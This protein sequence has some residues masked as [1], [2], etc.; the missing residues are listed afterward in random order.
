MKLHIVAHHGSPLGVTEKSIYGDGVQLGVGGSELYLLTM[1]RAWKEAGHDVTLYNNPRERGAS[2]FE[3]KNLTEFDPEEWRDVLIIFRAENPRTVAAKCGRKIFWSC[4]QFTVGNFY[5]LA[6]RVDK[7]VTI[8]PFH[9][10]YFRTRYNIENSVV[11]DIPVREWDY[12]G[13]SVEKDPMQVL[14]CSVPDRGINEL[15]R[16]WGPVTEEVPEAK[17]HI[18]SDYRLWDAGLS[19]NISLKHKIKFTSFPNVT[20]HALVPRPKLIELQIQ[21]AIQLYPCTYEELF[22]I[23]TAE[24]CYAGAYPIT[25]TCGALATTN[26]GTKIG[27]PI[28]D[29]EIR[30]FVDKTIHCLKNQETCLG[31]GSAVQEQA[32]ERF[33]IRKAI[34]KW[35]EVIHE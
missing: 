27:F 30:E 26:L 3:Q 29:K 7:V 28:G 14:F 16:I 9:Q 5:E 1:C 4:D 2:C 11:I 35:D 20:Y 25:S 19:A 33:S 34:Q 21:S 6:R 12:A 10:E 22:C 32:K 31:C 13:V 24:C 15:A 8:S 18:T 17:L 23:S